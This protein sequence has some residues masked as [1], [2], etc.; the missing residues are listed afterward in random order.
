M[1]GPSLPLGRAGFTPF[2]SPYP[3]P[4]GSRRIPNEQRRTGL[5]D[6]EEFKPSYSI[7]YPVLPTRAFA[8]TTK[9]PEPLAQDHAHVADCRLLL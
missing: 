9:G 4:A 7:G 2:S 3:P 6:L 8:Y 1:N 5:D